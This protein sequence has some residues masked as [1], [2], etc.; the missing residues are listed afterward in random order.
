MVAIVQLVFS[1]ADFSA[2]FSSNI[3]ETRSPF[4]SWFR[5]H[6][7]FASL[8][9]ISNVRVQWDIPKE[10]DR[11]LRAHLV[12]SL[13]GPKDVRLSVAVGTREEGHVLDQ[14]EDAHVDRLEHVDAFD[15]VLGGQRVWRSDDDRS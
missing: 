5:N 1:Q 13:V 12:H 9:V 14:A 2:D 8:A 15:S 11:M 7:W 3:Q 4:A 6:R 10:V